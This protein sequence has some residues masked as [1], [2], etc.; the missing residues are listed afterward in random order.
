[1]HVTKSRKQIKAVVILKSKHVSQTITVRPIIKRNRTTNVYVKCII[2]PAVPREVKNRG[3][4]KK[5]QQ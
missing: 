1:L 2:I 5:T 4:N 3:S